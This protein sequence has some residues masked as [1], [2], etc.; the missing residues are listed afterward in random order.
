MKYFLGIAAQ[1]NMTNEIIV[2]RCDCGADIA[3][4][5][6]FPDATVTTIHSPDE[7]WAGKGYPAGSGPV[8]GR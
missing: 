6:G 5:I 4:R 3:R 1:E 2:A 7:H 8:A